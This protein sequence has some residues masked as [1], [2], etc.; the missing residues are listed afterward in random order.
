[1]LWS[2]WAYVRWRHLSAGQ[3][4]VRPEYFTTQSVHIKGF[5]GIMAP[6]LPTMFRKHSGG[7]R[8][9]LFWKWPSANSFE[10]VN[11]GGRS[12]GKK[13]SPAFLVH[14]RCQS[15][16]VLRPGFI[17]PSPR[18]SDLRSLAGFTPGFS[19]DL[20]LQT[21]AILA[22]TVIWATSHIRRHFGPCS[23]GNGVDLWA[24]PVLWQLFN[25]SASFLWGWVPCHP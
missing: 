13:N 5:P 20:H 16:L 18:S 7:S 3:E 8:G 2:P 9:V 24:S 6:S 11:R 4:A 12:E 22:S 1:M 25:T 19:Q 10:D 17:P 21:A 15:P 23:F 14:L